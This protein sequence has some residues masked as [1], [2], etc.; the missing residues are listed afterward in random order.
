MSTYAVAL[1]AR[2]ASEPTV[3]T[4]VFINEQTPGRGREGWSRVSDTHRLV[5]PPPAEWT[6]DHVRAMLDALRRFLPPHAPLDVDGHV[7]LY[8][9]GRKG[10]GVKRAVLA[11]RA[12]G[13]EAEAY[14]PSLRWSS[15]STGVNADDIREQ[16]T[17][18]EPML[19]CLR[20][21]KALSP[22]KLAALRP[23]PATVTAVP[24][25][26]LSE[27]SAEYVTIELRTLLARFPRE[28]QAALL[29]LLEHTIARARDEDDEDA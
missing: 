28:K 29:T 7:N 4:E 21:L 13:W 11:V 25:S 15:L 5:V 6:P 19:D 9:S 10:Q 1:R 18:T 20:A 16:M 27:K 14:L 3:T 8:A 17:L 23:V 2:H 26:D 24:A 22:F 12:R